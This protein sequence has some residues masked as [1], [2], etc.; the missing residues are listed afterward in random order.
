MWA[1]L[2]PGHIG[3]IP[4]SSHWEQSRQ[5]LNIDLAGF[6]HGEGQYTQNR[7]GSGD[8]ALEALE[9]GRCPNSGTR[10][11]STSS[12]LLVLTNCFIDIRQRV[13]F[14]SQDDG[15]RKVVRDDAC[16]I[17][18]P[19]DEGGDDVAEISNTIAREVVLNVQLQRIRAAGSPNIELR[20]VGETLNVRQKELDTLVVL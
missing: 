2:S 18:A 4:G 11:H 13:C 5:R 15:V 10:G 7:I 20:L 8:V 1:L 19:C 6:G 17:R 12:L 16:C 9:A 14:A 3:G